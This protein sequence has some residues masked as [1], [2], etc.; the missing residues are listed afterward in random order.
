M[1]LERLFG[2]ALRPLISR[3]LN[4]Q[5]TPFS[6]ISVPP[7]KGGRVLYIH[8]PFCEALCSFCTFH[9]VQY[10]VEFATRYFRAL[11]IEIRRYVDQGFGFTD[12][13]FGGG[14]PTVN[15]D[16]LVQTIRLLRSLG[17]NGKISVETNPDHLKPDLINSLRD[18]GVARLSVGVQSFDDALLREMG[19]YERYGSGAEIAERLART[20]GVFDTLNAD[21]MFNFPH[22]DAASVR[23]DIDVLHS[24]GID[25]VS[26]YPLMPATQT[27]R[28]MKKHIGTINFSTEKALYR[29]IVSSMQPTYR[30][31]SAWCF[32]RGPA[33]IDEYIVDH[34]EY[35]GVGS[36]AFSYIGGTMYS[37]S[38]SIRRYINRIERGHTGTVMHRTFNVREQRRYSLLVGLFGL[39]MPHARL[40][41]LSGP[42]V[43]RALWK[44]L[45]LFR[46]LGAIRLQHDGYALTSRGMYLWVVMMREFLMGVN[47]FR[48]QMRHHIKSEHSVYLQ[49]L[50]RSMK[51]FGRNDDQLQ[52]APN[53]GHKLP[54]GDHRKNTGAA[55]K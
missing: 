38:F 6:D 34:D 55:G 31:T 52:P 3:T 36:G 12:V 1:A 40:K 54:D 29:Q 23:H 39:A 27:R 9:R 49:E 41:Q 37:T 10:D 51:S 50:T 45:L 35:L 17:I 44:E 2:V 13:Y 53:F 33:M 7:G 46:A 28:A 8:I 30:P 18:A 48:E 42:G 24:I 14:T 20:Q 22:Q 47:Q 26:F 21:L 16:Q 5:T 25:Q 19:R 11:H 32:S 4:F 43:P 15:P